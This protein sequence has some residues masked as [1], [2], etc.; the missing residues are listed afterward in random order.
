MLLNLTMAA[1]L[2]FTLAACKDDVRIKVVGNP[3]GATE[4]FKIDSPANLVTREVYTLTWTSNP[5]AKSYDVLIAKDAAC[6]DVVVKKEALSENKLTLD[7]LADGQ[8]FLC[9][10]ANAKTERFSASNNGTPLTIDTTQPSVAVPD[11]TQVFSKSFDPDLKIEDLTKVTVSWSQISG[12]G[13]ITFE[14]KN[15]QWPKLKAD[16]DGVYKIKATITDEAGNAVEQI[17]QFNWDQIGPSVVLAAPKVTAAPAAFA[18]TV[19]STAKSFEWTFTGPPGGILSFSDPA[20]KN[21]TITANF[22]GTYQV[23]LTAKDSNGNE[24]SDTKAFTWDKTAPIFT[25]QGL[26][27][28]A[29]DGFLNIQDRILT[30]T[31]LGSLVADGYTQLGYA[32]VSGGVSCDSSLSYGLTSPK[33]NSTD[34]GVDGPYKVCMQLVDGAGNTSYGASSLITLD[35]A[36]AL[37][38]SIALAGDAIDGIISLSEHAQ[39]NDLVS[40]LI[41][42]DAFIAEYALVANGTA[43]SGPLTYGTALPK[44]NDTRFVASGDYR[45][46]VRVRDEALNPFAYGQ[47]SLIAFSAAAPT[48]FSLAKTGGGSDG[49]VNDSEKAAATALWTLNQS[50]GTLIAYTPP[51]DDTG[52]AVVCDASQSYSS[53]TIASEADLLSDGPWVICVKLRD[54]S[55]NTSYGKSDTIIRDVGY[56]VLTSLN[57]AG[58]ASD[59]FINNNEKSDTGPAWSL[60]SSGQSS[61]AYTAL[62]D[63]TA[64]AVVCNAAKTYDQSTI[65]TIAALASDGP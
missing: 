58:L 24:G 50:G 1:L 31:I 15:S 61:I 57:G 7:F 35:T 13:I 42:N 21:P 43:C 6:T 62:L 36:P 28:P 55:G 44:G 56:P 52:G 64:A 12:D 33:A 39:T 65:P 41:A 11:D 38:T 54:G 2:A 32:V 16:V 63:D 34:F 29:S 25:S 27:G 5:A 53:A 37:F 47:S 30:S 46:C 51:L 48:F 10:F 59:G 23:T 49:F 9:V 18:V 14:D 45:V 8:Y 17:F 19:D 4:E 22:E 26:A 3:R 20:A 40:G 60:V